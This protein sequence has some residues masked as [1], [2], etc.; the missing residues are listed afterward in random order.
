SG[1]DRGRES[2]VSLGS[3]AILGRDAELSEVDRFL[4]DVPDGPAALVLEG[5]AGI[6]KTTLWQAAGNL[7]R[8]R[9]FRVLTTRAAES[10]ARLSY[11]ALGDLL[12]GELDDAV[13]GLPPPQRAALETALLRTTTGAAP[14]QR[15]VSLASL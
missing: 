8:T 5:V 13:Q 6:G 14:D 1:R 10:E 12:E 4:E 15:A 11:T 2:P 9:D 3:N 7:A